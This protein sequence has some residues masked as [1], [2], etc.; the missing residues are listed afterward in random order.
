MPLPFKIAYTFFVAAGVVMFIIG[1]WTGVG[2]IA[3]IGG[4]ITFFTLLPN[5]YDPA[6]RLKEYNLR[7]T[8]K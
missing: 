4:L 8:Q 7:K 2:A 5:K 3:T 6:I 1:V